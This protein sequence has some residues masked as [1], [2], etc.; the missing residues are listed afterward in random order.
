MKVPTCKID[1]KVCV[2]SGYAVHA[3]S[4]AIP[5]DPSVMAVTALK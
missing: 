5:D 4:E 1:G 2:Y 3:F